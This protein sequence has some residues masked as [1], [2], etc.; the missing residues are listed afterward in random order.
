[1]SPAPTAKI[2][3]SKE[4]LGGLVVD[5]LEAEKTGFTTA[6]NTT[7]PY[8]NTGYLHDNNDEKGSQKARFTPEIPRAGNY[9]VLMTYS[10]N[11]N[12]ATNVPVTIHS[13]DG[14]TKIF[15]NQQLKPSIKDV[16]IQ[17]GV[18]RFNAGKNGYVEVRN[19]DTD[20][21][22]IIDAIQWLEEPNASTTQE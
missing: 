5:D 14:D 13:A 6:G 4:A 1:V 2:S 21:Y 10:P 9:R 18:F 17:L 7:A 20:G 11:K 3:L 8:V 15:V 22:V 19:D 16:S 12:R